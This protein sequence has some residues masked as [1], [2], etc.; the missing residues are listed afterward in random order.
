MRYMLMLY[1]DETA[2]A[3]IPPEQM[4]KVMKG[5]HAYQEALTKAGA[6][7]ETG[8]L[9]PTA[10]A[11]VVQ[12]VGG[13]NRLTDNGF[14]NEGGSL[15]VHDGPYAETRERMGGYFMIEAPDMEAALAWAGK[16]PAAQW[17]PVEVRPLF[18]LLRQGEP[19]WCADGGYATPA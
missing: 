14:V 4:A 13:Q 15:Q 11:K 17:G 2:G 19:A 3:Q 16:C 8:A 1:A 10:G 9:A 6:F 12:V 18:N 7:I 5:M